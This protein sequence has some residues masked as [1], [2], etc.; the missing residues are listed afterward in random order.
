[1]SWYISKDEIDDGTAVG[2][3]QGD[4][5]TLEECKENCSIAFRMLDDDREIY[6]H[7]KSSDSSSF[8]PLDNFGTPNAGCTEIQYYESGKWVTL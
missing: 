8:D 1:M 2:Q 3:W 4:E 5:Y 6:Y 7:G